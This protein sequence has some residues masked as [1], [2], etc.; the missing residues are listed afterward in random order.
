MAAKPKEMYEVKQIL[1]LRSSG[2]GIK[3]IANRLGISK[4]TVRKYVRKLEELSIPVAEAALYSEQALS[5]LFHSTHSKAVSKKYTEL[6]A[7]F[8]SMRKELVRTG[9]TRKHLWYSYKKQYPKGYNYAQFCYHY[10][11]WQKHQSVSMSIQ[12][13]AGDKLF[14][15]YTGKHLYL[16]DSVTGQQKAVEVYVGILGASQLIYVEATESQKQADYISSVE[17]N[18]HYIGGVPQ[19]IVPDNL[20]AAVQTSSRYEAQLNRCFSEFA[21]HYQTTVLPTR[22]YKPKDKALV[23]NAV[24]IVYQQIF[25]P[26]RNEVFH[27]LKTLNE[28][29]RTELEKL[30]SKPL[31][32]RNY[33]R[34]D[35]FYEL[36]SKLLQPLPVQKY[37]IKTYARL[38]VLKNAHIYVKQDKHYYSIP[39]RYVGQEVVVILTKSSVEVYRNYERIALHPRSKEAYA[40]T[41][42][43][44]HLHPNHRFMK[45]LNADFFLER[46]EKIGPAT[47]QYVHKIIFQKAHP[48]KGYKSS[49]GILKLAKHYSEDRLEAVCTL[50]HEMEEYSYQTLLRMLETQVDLQPKVPDFD[51]IE[52]GEHLNIRGENYYQ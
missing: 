5:G 38:R 29:I 50:A 47:Y 32:H 24:K 20:K 40:Y 35:C 33:S 11:E 18:L 36:E 15:D 10:R 43:T 39:Y 31:T 12:H 1:L 44:D 26:L 27:D 52:L 28:A 34:K 42:Q 16:T 41:T 3:A 45:K 48:E 9:V 21:K 2:L 17:N 49:L 6:L 19:A 14:V 30:N 8:P 22:A 51:P 46:A 25:A 13:K 23:E 37:S 7:Y 4:N